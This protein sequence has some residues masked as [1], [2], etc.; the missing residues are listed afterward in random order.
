V[1]AHEYRLGHFLR[2][3]NERGIE[4]L[5][6]LTGR[7]LHEYKLWRRD[8]GDLNEVSV[9]SQMD[10]LRVFIRWCES[11]DA[12][13]DDL[14]S[15][16]L[17]PDLSNGENQ[18][19]VMLE[20]DA[21][22]D[23]LKYLSRFEY[24]S[25]DHVLLTLLWRTGMRTGAV[26]GLDISDYDSEDALLA[27]RHRPETPLKNK[28]DGGRLVALND[29]TCSLLD[30]WLAHQRPDV[31]DNA[32]R[33]PF[34]ATTH[35]RPHK[36]TIREKVYR[37]TR[38]CQFRGKCP[39]GRDID[40]CEATDGH[41]KTASKCPSSVSPHAIRRGSITHH[42]SEDVPEKIVSDR[43]NVGVEVLDKH[44]DRRSEETKA[45]QRREYLDGV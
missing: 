24:A 39:H 34:L 30:D 17:S 40:T 27:I 20:P 23:L 7:Q 18:R 29:D 6:T 11:I 35:G 14:S 9:K 5:N 36:T 1:N 31:T 43:M 21:A 4:N 12:V 16:V 44:Y 22:T 15:K 37:W 41:N 25:L 19:D 33:E 2:W 8:D 26:H 45:E 42:L 3:C 10:T 13:Q 28:E 38:P 32:G